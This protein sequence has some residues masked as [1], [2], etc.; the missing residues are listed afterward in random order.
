VWFVTEPGW[1]DVDSWK[2]NSG[3]LERGIGGSTEW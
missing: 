2:L 3:I 1:L